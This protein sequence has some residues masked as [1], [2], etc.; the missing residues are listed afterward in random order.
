VLVLELE[1]QN[2]GVDASG[3]AADDDPS[4]SAS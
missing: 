2:C 1:L 3:A 4:L